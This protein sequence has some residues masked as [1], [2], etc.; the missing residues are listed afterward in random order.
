M[1]TSYTR[2]V[3][4]AL[5]DIGDCAVRLI[6]SGDVSIPLAQP[7]LFEFVNCRPTAPKL[8]KA[9]REQRIRVVINFV[10]GAASVV[11]ALAQEKCTR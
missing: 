9:K 3:A 10:L 11:D 8:G 1:H 4:W 6:R 5:P 7:E 2:T